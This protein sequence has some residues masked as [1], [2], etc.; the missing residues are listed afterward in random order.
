MTKTIN[1]D[2]TQINGNAFVLMGAFRKQAKRERWADAEIDEVINEAKKAD[3][4]HLVSKLS[5][6]CSPSDD[7]DCDDEE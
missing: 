6:H 3:Y 2:L 4:A 1:L 5:A 7:D